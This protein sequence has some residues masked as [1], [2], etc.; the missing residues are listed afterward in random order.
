MH[1]ADLNSGKVVLY[2]DGACSGNPGPGGFGTLLLF[3]NSSGLHKKELSGGYRETTNNRMELLGVIKGLEALHKVS[4]VAVYSDSKYIVDAYNKNWIAG[5]KKQR[6]LSTDSKK[7]IKNPDLWR[8]LLELTDKH[9]VEFNWVKGHS[10]V[11]ENERCDQLAV[12]ASRGQN[13]QSDSG[14]ITD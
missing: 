6:R 13:L 1:T 5:W 11:P 9:S 3:K 7:P 10:G 2:S 8:V 12:D 14:R 4:S